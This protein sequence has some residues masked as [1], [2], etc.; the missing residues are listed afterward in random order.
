MSRVCKYRFFGE[1]GADGQK[2]KV[3]EARRYMLCLG[4][5][6]RICEDH[7]EYRMYFRNFRDRT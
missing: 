1:V 6:I 2:K 7:A 3:L 4:K 5:C